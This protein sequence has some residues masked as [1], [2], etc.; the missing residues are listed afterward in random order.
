[1]VN[2]T[3]YVVETVTAGGGTTKYQGAV[4]C[5]AI[6]SQVA[7]FEWHYGTP[8]SNTYRK[9]TV[10][11]TGEPV[12][13]APP[14]DTFADSAAGGNSNDCG[15]AVGSQ[16]PIQSGNFVVSDPALLPCIALSGDG[17]AID[18]NCNLTTSF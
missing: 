6:S 14:T 1:V 8:N 18:S 7:T 15:N 2:P 16:T 9:A 11:D 17:W 5:L 13:P 3:G 10:T 12:S 4:S